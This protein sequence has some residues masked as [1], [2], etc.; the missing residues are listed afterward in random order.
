M[1]VFW[2]S[3]KKDGTTWTYLVRL[4]TQWRSIE[5]MITTL[6]AG[7]WFVGIPDAGPLKQFAV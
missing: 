7:P 2:L 5:G 1:R 6:G 3:G 4:V